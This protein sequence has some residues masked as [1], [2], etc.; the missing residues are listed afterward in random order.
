MD[1]IQQHDIFLISVLIIAGIR[2][3]HHIGQLVLCQRIAV[4]VINRTAG[5]VYKRQVYGEDAA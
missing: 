4:S 1:Q 5:D 3:G 2:K